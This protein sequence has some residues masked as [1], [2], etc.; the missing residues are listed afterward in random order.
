[1]KTHLFVL[2]SLVCFVLEEVKAANC[3]A[4]PAGLV[5]WWTGDG[6]AMDAVS[7]QGGTLYGGVTFAA[8]KVG[9]AFS[10]DG[11]RAAVGTS[12]PSFA[13]V[14]DTF[15]MEFWAFPTQTRAGTPEANSGSP[16]TGGQRYAIYPE[17]GGGSGG[18]GAGVSVGTNG[19]S[20][21]EHAVGYLPSLLV[22]DASITGWT[23]IAVVYENKQPK[24]YVNGSLV[25][26]GLTSASAFVFPSQTLGD[27]GFYGPHAGLLDEVGIY[28][29]A[30][31]GSEIQSIF[32][33]DSAGKCNTAAA[34]SGSVPY[35]TDLEQGIGP[36]W[37]LSTVDNSQRG[38]SSFTGRFGN[39][40]QTLR[41]GNLTAG[42]SYTLGFDFY[43]IDTWDGVGYGPDYFN[44]SLDGNQVF[45]ETFSNY[46]GDP[47]SQPQS[48]PGTPD[49]GRVN[50][51]FHP[52]YVDAIYRNIEITFTAS[53][54]AAQFTFQGQNLEAIDNESW[55]LDNVS[56]RR[57]SDLAGTIIRGTTLPAPGFP[58]SAAID[59]FSIF[60]SRD[61]LNS[62]AID[63]ANYSL[64][65]AG[66]N[67]TFGDSDDT[68]FTL[69]P[70]HTAGKVVSFTPDTVPLQPGKYRFETKAGLLDAGTNAVTAFTSDFV[71]VN[72]V[73]GRIENA[74]NDSIPGATPLPVT[75]SPAGSG[76]F[77]TVGV[78][79]FSANRE[80]DYWRFDAE[81]GDR[82]SVW[83]E[84]QNL[85]GLSAALPAKCRRPELG[86]RGWRLR[87]Q[88]AVSELPVWQPGHF[89][90]AHL[91]R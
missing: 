16:G 64:R 42:Q 34:P 73:L 27:T 74:E 36:E 43:V 31:S 6:D 28:N 33:A 52:S 70:S 71:I 55:G 85:G 90:P 47:P 76:L 21:F 5:R 72:P 30:L 38:F 15:T 58:S 48:Y 9:L 80:V 89:L 46:N 79:T 26:T 45:H 66:A 18:S 91:Y 41:V 4:P 39:N 53:N 19:I 14:Q 25:K 82:L 49:G 69:T 1:M 60:A 50:Y 59:R 63:V 8:G 75:E 2:L 17:H 54:S 67:L 44:V 11:V 20:V 22:Y 86:D 35:F 77:T 40:A 10:L 57:T 61:L 83:V 3:V 78:G 29:R 65:E 37:G 51:G 62:S 84:A 24:L 68:V 13:D 81:A 23:H 7:G 12:L 88:C 56:V 87:R 32:A